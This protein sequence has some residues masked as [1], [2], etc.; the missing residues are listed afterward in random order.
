VLRRWQSVRDERSRTGCPVAVR[1]RLVDG[2]PGQRANHIVA[3]AVFLPPTGPMSEK[4][5]RQT[6]IAPKDGEVQRGCFPTAT[7][8]GDRPAKRD[9]PARHGVGSPHNRIGQKPKRARE[10][11]PAGLDAP[12][13]SRVAPRACG[14]EFLLLEER[15]RGARRRGRSTWASAAGI[16]EPHR[17]RPFEITGFQAFNSKAGGLHQVIGLAIETAAARNTLP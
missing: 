15:L 7:A 6:G 17:S 4:E 13:F 2:C 9:H 5:F 11:G 8:C 3:V 1:N 10:I 14:D 12:R 16:D